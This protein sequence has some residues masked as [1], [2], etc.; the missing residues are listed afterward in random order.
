MVGHRPSDI[1]AGDFAQPN[2]SAITTIS[3]TAYFA[4]S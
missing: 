4:G 2:H 3:E 1:K